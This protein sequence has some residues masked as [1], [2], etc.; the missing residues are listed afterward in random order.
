MSDMNTPPV[1]TSVT[2][3]TLLTVICI[4]S[5][6]M[7]AWGIFSGIQTMTTDQTAAIEEAR[8]K[9]EEAKAQLGDQA[10]GMAGR[11]MDSAMEITERAAQNAKPMGIAGIVLALI[12][13]LGVW[14]MW[15][16]KKS[17]FWL[18]LL[19]AIGGLAVP[20]IYLGG[21]VVAL[22]SVGFMGFFSLIFIILY[23][24]NLKYMH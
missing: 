10:D 16:L 13:L 20:I 21:S 6:I 4:L 14:Q 5:F 19:A 24:V 8:T 22:A 15:N 11:M 17:G 12:S 1:G 23:A 7:G 2:R 18:Y 3:P 9:M